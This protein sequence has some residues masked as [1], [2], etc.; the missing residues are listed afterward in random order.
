MPGGRGSSYLTQ[1]VQPGDAIEIEG[2]YGLAYLRV[3]S[4]RD[5]VCVAGGSGLAPV[6]SI[7]RGASESGLLEERRLHFFYGGRT[8][9]DICGEQH[10]RTLPGYGERIGYWPVVSDSSAGASGAAAWAGATGFV[11]DAV[12]A[13]LGSVL[14]NYEFYFAGPPAMSQALQQMLM[15]EHQVPYDQV[16]FDRFF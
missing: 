10:L 8:P 5:I 16:H 11:H 4:P 14:K 9:R 12:K 1:S 13:E 7:A 6:I 3:D 2:P 15:V